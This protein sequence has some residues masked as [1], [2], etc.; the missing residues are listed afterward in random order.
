M[1]IPIGI[2]AALRRLSGR[3]LMEA[4]SEKM[5]EFFTTTPVPP[6]ML[7]D[8]GHAADRKCNVP[9]QLGV[10]VKGGA[11]MIIAGVRTHLGLNPGHAVASDDKKNGFN[12]MWR[13][14]I[15]RGLRRWFPELIPTVRLSGTRGAAASL[16]SAPS[17]PTAMAACTTRRRAVPRVIRS[18]RFS[19]PLATTRRSSGLPGERAGL[20]RRAA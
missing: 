1:L 15:F 20:L 2:P 6:D 5:G 9:Q 8:A 14:A 19:G 18:A 4:Y 3:V 10:G 17:L 13:R 7:V 12:T 11:E 16:P